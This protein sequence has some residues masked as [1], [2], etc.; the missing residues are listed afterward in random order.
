MFAHLAVIRSPSVAV[1]SATRGHTIS[2]S[3]TIRIPHY[4]NAIDALP[5]VLDPSIDVAYIAICIICWV[6]RNIVRQAS[7]NR[8]VYLIISSVAVRIPNEMSTRA[9]TPFN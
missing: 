7:V 2:I 5:E 9:Q 1:D 4:R 8:H 3:F 6:V